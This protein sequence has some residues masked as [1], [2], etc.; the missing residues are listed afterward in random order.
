MRSWITVRLEEGEIYWTGGGKWHNREIDAYIRE[1][2]DVK[3]FVTENKTLNKILE[4]TKI[5]PEDVHLIRFDGITVNRESS[6]DDLDYG[7]VPADAWIEYEDYTFPDQECEKC[8]Y[9]WD[10]FDPDNPGPFKCLECGYDPGPPFVNRTGNIP[11]SKLGEDYSYCW[12]CDRLTPNVVC[13]KCKT[14]KHTSGY[15]CPRCR[16]EPHWILEIS[17]A[18]YNMGAA[19]EFGGS[20]YD[21]DELWKCQLCGLEYWISNGN[22]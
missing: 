19:M 1:G 2:E 4:H 17:D 13:K 20:P 6:Y 3:C 14:T 16:Y 15:D 18:K 7:F 12:R 9:S 11:H 21:W 10:S 5:H 8:G 22:Y